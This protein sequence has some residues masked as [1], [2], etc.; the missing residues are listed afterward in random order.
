MRFHVYNNVL[1][2]TIINQ[3]YLYMARLFGSCIYTVKVKAAVIN[4]CYH[5]NIYLATHGLNLLHYISN[6][7]TI[8]PKNDEL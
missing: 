3:I 6:C 2:D 1:V 5:R 4:H 7:F 8:T